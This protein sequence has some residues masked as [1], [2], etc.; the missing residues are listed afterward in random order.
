[1][2][3][4][5]LNDL[6]KKTHPWE[7]S[8][9]YHL[10]FKFLK[11][12]H[13][14][15]LKLFHSILNKH[16]NVEFSEKYWEII[17]SNYIFQILYIFYE[18]REC[19]KSFKKIKTF[20]LIKNT[21]KIGSYEDL[22]TNFEFLHE[23][24]HAK[25]IEYYFPQKKKVYFEK[26]FKLKKE[27]K[28]KIS[29]NFI[30]NYLFE[31][32]LS[33][34]FSFK[35][36]KNVCN[37][38]SKSLISKI[39]LYSVFKKFDIN[40]NFNNKFDIN[41][42]RRFFGHKD[43]KN[44]D[45]LLFSLMIDLLPLNYL[46]NFKYLF[47]L[48]RKNYSITKLLYIEYFD[49][50]LRFLAAQV[51][52]NN[53]K[54][55]IAQHGG[56]YWTFKEH[57]SREYEIKIADYYF[58]WGRK[59]SKGNSIF[60]FSKKKNILKNKGNDK[61]IISLPKLSDFHRS[62]DSSTIF[63]PKKLLNDCLILFYKNLNNQIK[64]NLFFKMHVTEKKYHDLLK[65]KFGDKLIKFERGEN[66]FS[67]DFKLS[68]H[69]YFGSSFLESMINN[70]PSILIIQ[71]FDANDKFTVSQL[72]NLKKYHVVFTSSK[73]ASLFI[74]KNWKQISEWWNCKQVKNTREKFLK[75]FAF[76]NN[77]LN[78]EILNLVSKIN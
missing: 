78:N 2:K 68:I 40:L 32:I 42:R 67:E 30:L 1:M 41:K 65:Q 36:N 60:G 3:S 33:I 53:G 52:E 57:F 71:N 74:N 23:Y 70:I 47:N 48:I 14:K 24:I 56:N 7:N 28:K 76:N 39:K 43:F 5:S 15:F 27:F 6:M 72:K 58:P 8:N 77:N 64:K 45:K 13:K 21:P 46:E 26:F 73:K 25:I 35:K 19:I 59:G 12:E 16:H 4:K 37:V 51:K 31:K 11:K 55:I 9:Y 44:E 54:L 49:D 50:P 10:K 63:K 17:L 22:R 38:G 18:R 62:L 34:L 75:N 29:L 66:F 20:K 69:T 61:C